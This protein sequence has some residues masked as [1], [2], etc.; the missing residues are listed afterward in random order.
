MRSRIRNSLLDPQVA[1]LIQRSRRSGSRIHISSIRSENEGSL[2]S[3]HR[4]QYALSGRSKR[5]WKGSIY[6][7]FG[8]KRRSKASMGGSGSDARDKSSNLTIICRN[9]SLNEARF[10]RRIIQLSNFFCPPHNPPVPPIFLKER[11][12]LR[13][14]ARGVQL[15][16]TNHCEVYCAK[17]P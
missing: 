5:R 12:N 13:D 14:N 7:I 3:T 2:A 6:L 1:D 9:M 15:I 17:S 8:K 4:C 10:G 16:F 11:I